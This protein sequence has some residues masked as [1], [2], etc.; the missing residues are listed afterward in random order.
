MRYCK[1][2]NKR[3]L[4]KLFFQIRFNLWLFTWVNTS[5]ATQ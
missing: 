4:F 3:Y 1:T 5:F 2:F